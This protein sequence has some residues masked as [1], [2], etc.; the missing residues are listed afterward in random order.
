MGNAAQVGSRLDA[1]RKIEKQLHDQVQSLFDEALGAGQAIVRIHADLDFDDQTVSKEI[2][3]SPVKGATGLIREEQSDTSTEVAPA[4]ATVGVVATNAGGA[5][6]GGPLGQNHSERKVTYELNHTVESMN[7]GAGQLKKI[8]VSVLLKQEQAPAVLAALK[9]AVSRTVGL[10]AARGDALSLAVIPA[11][12][13]AAPAAVAEAATALKEDGQQQRW[14]MLASVLAPWVA[15]I[16]AALLLSAL[17]W[18]ALRLPAPPAPGRAETGA[19]ANGT[20]GPALPLP[21]D[22]DLQQLVERY[23]SSAAQVLR[24]MMS[25]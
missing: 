3:E 25:N 20:G 2:Y 18:R 22:K 7:H 24:R 12:A 16:I 4:G 19:G 17:A 14:L 13:A 23:P 1:S 11:K 21:P 8:S 5:G 15:V 10:D 6:A 9:D